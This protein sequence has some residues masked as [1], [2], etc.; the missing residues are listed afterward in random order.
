MLTSSRRFAVICD[1][2]A[3]HARSPSL[4]FIVKHTLL[5]RPRAFK[6]DRK[7]F[8]TRAEAEAERMRQLTLRERGGHEAIGLPLHELS[9]IIQARRTLAEHGKYCADACDWRV[10]WS[11][12]AL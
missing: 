10:C 9:T 2:E 5:S 1:H 7:F 6:Q 12:K 4:P 11:C 3:R 8:R